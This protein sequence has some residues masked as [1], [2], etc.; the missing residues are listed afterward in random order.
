MI[1]WFNRKDFM[2]V[3]EQKVQIIR[4]EIELDFKRKMVDVKNSYQID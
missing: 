3:F 4:L 1:D 2:A